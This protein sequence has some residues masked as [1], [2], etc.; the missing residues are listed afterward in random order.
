MPGDAAEQDRRI[1]DI[2]QALFRASLQAEKLA[3]ETG[4]PLVLW[5]DGHVVEVRLVAESHMS[6]GQSG[7]SPR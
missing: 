1:R 2:E 6:G 4:T 5:E 3:R 7:Q